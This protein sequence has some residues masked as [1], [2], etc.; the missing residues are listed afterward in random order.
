[1]S[2]RDYESLFKSTKEAML[3]KLEANKHKPPFDDEDI[4]DIFNKLCIEVSELDFEMIREGNW[5]KKKYEAT[6]I[7]NYGAII[8]WLCDKAIER[9]KRESS[10]EVSK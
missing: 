9:E 2:E 7:V 6:D 10:D 5:L 8:I 1:M 4:D 3:Y